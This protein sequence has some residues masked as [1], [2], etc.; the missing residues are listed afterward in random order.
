MRRTLRW[1]GAGLLVALLVILLVRPWV[2]LMCLPP[3]PEQLPPSD[4][5]RQPPLQPGTFPGEL[6]ELLASTELP[7]VPATGTREPLPPEVRSRFRAT[8]SALQEKLEEVLQA[9][10]GH[11]IRPDKQQESL[12]LLSN[13]RQLARLLELSGRLALADGDRDQAR[14]TAVLLIRMG[15]RL[16]EGTSAPG[17]LVGIAV[18]HL[19]CRLLLLWMDSPE[20]S[21]EELR[22]L[23][24][25]LKAL[26]EKR[27]SWDELVR[28][29][30]AET[31]DLLKKPTGITKAQALLL[32]YLGFLGPCP[33]SVARVVCRDAQ[34]WDELPPE[35]LWLQPWRPSGPDVP[36]RVPGLS[37]TR[38]SLDRKVVR[39]PFVWSF[40]SPFRHLLRAHRRAELSTRIVFATAAAHTHRLTTGQWPRTLSQEQL[41]RVG[42]TSTDVH[43]PFRQ[44]QLLWFPHKGALLRR[45]RQLA[46][47]GTDPSKE[48]LRELRN[49][50]K[51][52]PN[53]SP[54]V[55]VPLGASES[56][57]DDFGTSLFLVDRAAIEWLEERQAARWDPESLRDSGQLPAPS[58]SQPQ[59]GPKRAPEAASDRAGDDGRD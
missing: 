6:A 36:P 12:D 42:L 50:L 23:C 14:R 19:G 46:S 58:R 51:D 24:K 53:S 57:V 20:L 34:N 37:I 31:R 7:A 27:E 28:W 38:A 55:W 43:D 56:S 26:K 22:G 2:W 59:A 17:F 49:L 15:R 54:I 39:N 25:Q 45:A 35:K 40:V 5:L 33:I 4:Q 13:V 18:E 10:R 41:A 11:W 30:Y 9:P 3:I 52:F 21:A 47:E 8:A 32:N 48:R 1:V 29:K 16:T 44:Q